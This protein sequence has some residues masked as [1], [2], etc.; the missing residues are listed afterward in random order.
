M[1]YPSADE[2]EKRVGSKY[3]LVIAVAKRA[4]QLREGAPKLVE[5]KSTNPI[6]IALEE[7]ACG[8]IK[9]VAPTPEQLEAVREAKAAPGVPSQVSAA[10]ELLRA[11]AGESREESPEEGAEEPREAREPEGV[12][13]AAAAVTDQPE[14][15]ESPEAAGVPTVSEAA[16]LQEEEG[17]G[18]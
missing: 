18:I 1:I 14:A 3:S 11:S 4:K 15:E 7:I 16:E 10:V 8:K 12:P 13:V 17:T 5:S 9:I 2:L 6:T